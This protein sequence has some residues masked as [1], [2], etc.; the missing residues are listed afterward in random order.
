MK[1]MALKKIKRK[2]FKQAVEA[3]P[4]VQNCYQEGKL[5]IL[6][7]ERN[8]VDLTNPGK[9]GGSLFIDQCLENQKMYADE[10]RWDYAIDYNG[11]VFFFE[12]HTASTS[13]VTTVLRKLQWLK[14]WLNQKAPEINILRSNSPYFWVQSNGYHILANSSEDRRIRQKGLKP[15]PKLVLK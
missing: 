13:E 7:K 5:A 1:I 4:D 14:D 9:C 2:T 12:V 8:K 3:T 6:R 10:S 11:E 15:I